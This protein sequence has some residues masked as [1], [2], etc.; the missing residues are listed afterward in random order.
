ML[1]LADHEQEASSQYRAAWDTYTEN[2]VWEQH[3][4][5]VPGEKE[6]V[7]TLTAQ[8][9]NY[10]ARG[11]D[12]FSALSAQRK[13]LYF[14]RPDAAGLAAA[15]EEIKPTSDQII[16][17]NQDWMEHVNQESRRTADSSLLGYGIGLA[18]GIV[19]AVLLVASTIRAIRFPIGAMAESAT[20]IGAGDLDQVVSVTSDDELG[21]L[22]S[23][24][25]T[26]ARQ[27]R[28]LRQ[29]AAAKLTVQQTSQATIDAFP[30]PVLVVESGAARRDGESGRA[31]FAGLSPPQADDTRP[32]T[33]SRRRLSASRC[34]T[35]C[36][37]SAPV[38]PR[39]FRQGGRAASRRRDWLV[40]SPCP[41]DLRRPRR[42]GGARPCCWKTSPASACSTK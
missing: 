13:P 15:P 17:I 42:D 27:L 24:F 4:I 2:L 25:K 37:S 20:A 6:L 19:L 8:T 14:G 28:E 39:G 7:A 22:A 16:K 11:N 26:M 32:R 12:F 34:P 10:R 5:T 23:R 38:R 18:A 9:K 21:Q 35:R 29:S 36:A 30:D 40:S 41:A 3:N 33:G 1:A 31:P